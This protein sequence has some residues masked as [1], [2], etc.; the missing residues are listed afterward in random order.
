MTNAEIKQ[1]KAVENLES[2]KLN[3]FETEFVNSIKSM[4]KK[5]L[6]KLSYKQYD[7][8]RKIADK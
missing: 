3:A 2:G 6:N 5:Q 7:I 8:L 4:S 1:A